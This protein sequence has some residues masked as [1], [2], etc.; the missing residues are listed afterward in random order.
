[1]SV[2]GV[3]LAILLSA[4]P[5]QESASTPLPN[6][7]GAR[8]LV[9]LVIP[10]DRAMALAQAERLEE[11]G[12][13]ALGMG[14]RYAAD[15]FEV[16]LALRR[17]VS[18]PDPQAIAETMRLLAAAYTANGYAGVAGELLEEAAAFGQTRQLS[19][20]LAEARAREGDYSRTRQAL[21][22][23]GG[24]DALGPW[25]QAFLDAMVTMESGDLAAAEQKLAIVTE[26][27]SDGR[28]FDMPVHRFR[29]LT[30]LVR[31]RQTLGLT[32]GALAATYDLIALL[33][34]PDE[35]AR[36][37][38]DLKP[39]E[40]EGETSQIIAT[41]FE[42]GI[43]ADHLGETGEGAKLLEGGLG[44]NRFL[45]YGDVTSSNRFTEAS[46]RLAEASL[47]L[48]Q[49]G[50]AIAVADTLEASEEPVLASVIR[51]RASIGDSGV[52]GQLEAAVEATGDGASDGHIHGHALHGY[53]LSVAAS[54]A[55]AL[56][57]NDN[58]LAFAERAVEAFRRA[59]DT[60]RA[61]DPLSEETARAQLAA[62]LTALAALQAREG[63]VDQAEPKVQEALN[64]Q[65][66]L[67]C[68][69]A[70]GPQP[71]AG[72]RWGRDPRQCLG[73][74]A[75]SVTVETGAAIQTARERPAAALRLYRHAGDIALGHT[76]S[77]YSQQDDARLE[78]I[79][80]ARFHR[81]FVASA[82]QAGE[83]DGT[84][85]RSDR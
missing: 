3:F 61:W 29:A 39:R 50:M 58:A 57:R 9:G 45:I 4:S 35:F 55:A 42:A 1:M 81:A 6:R 84:G 78:F 27:P 85:S 82:W 54:T 20:A 14:F 52:L 26:A 63:L 10:S 49:P 37:E 76:L 60:G 46:I 70:L 5:L 8:A 30:A 56:G 44:L 40:A 38:D 69:A 7:P 41:V 17:S 43:R 79:R 74:P 31:T 59:V 33:R 12:R 21:I 32:T 80:S 77:R 72:Y 25:D 2:T 19:S 68:P 53:A 23:S 71:T 67:W 13:D 18:D 65:A 51:A 75:L 47:I 11:D 36:I 28:W 62:G 15:R 66:L 22:V 34:S 73:H 48:D 24:L 64:L 16:A 83:A